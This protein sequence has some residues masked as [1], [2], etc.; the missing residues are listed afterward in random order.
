MA[1]ADCWVPPNVGGSTAGTPPGGGLGPLSHTLALPLPS[2]CET[3]IWKS[4]SMF[5]S[6]GMELNVLRPGARLLC[7]GRTST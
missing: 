3:R 7:P 4:G 2:A 1:S 5:G 6:P